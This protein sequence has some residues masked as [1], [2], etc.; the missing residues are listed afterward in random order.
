MESVAKV[1]KEEK[2]TLD[3]F[4]KKN[5]LTGRERRM[6]WRERGEIEEE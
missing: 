5:L 3:C 6:I 2:G 4:G 1:F